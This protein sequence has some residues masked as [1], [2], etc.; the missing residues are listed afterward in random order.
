MIA[1]YQNSILHRSVKFFDQRFLLLKLL[2]NKKIGIPRIF[3]CLTSSQCKIILHIFPKIDFHI[4][5]LYPSLQ[6]TK[7]RS[8]LK[9]ETIRTYRQLYLMENL[10]KDFAV[11]KRPSKMPGENLNFVKILVSKFLEPQ[12]SA[13]DL[14]LV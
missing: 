12:H 5:S 10:K 3:Y 6:I 4:P 13:S 2:L 7:G 14:T 9:Y 1:I 8:V 11:Q